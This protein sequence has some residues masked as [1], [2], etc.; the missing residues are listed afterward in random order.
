MKPDYRTSAQKAAET[1][2]KYKTD[3]PLSVLEQMPNVLL[4][5]IEAK[6]DNGKVNC[7]FDAMTVMSKPDGKARYMVIY[8]KNISPVRLRFALARELGHIVLQ[9]DDSDPD[10]VR[11]E[12]AGSFAHYLFRPPIKNSRIQYRPKH[13]STLWEMKNIRVFDSVE[14][15]KKYV[16][17]EGN[18]FN[19]FIGKIDKYQPEDVEISSRSYF[20]P[21]SS[22]KSCHEVALGGKIIGYC[23]K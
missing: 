19:R 15:L 6:D 4:I 13:Q 7:N 21:V 18:K 2:D 20:D 10:D 11:S 5:A 23:V 1:L 8:N 12:E 9:H 14:H 17:D 16:V 22:W 3:D